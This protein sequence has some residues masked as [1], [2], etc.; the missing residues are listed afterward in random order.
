M[1][2][3]N[4]QEKQF[5]QLLLILAIILLGGKSS[6]QTILNEVVPVLESMGGQ[7]LSGELKQAVRSAEEISSYIAAFG[8]M[9][10]AAN[11]R[12]APAEAPPAASAKPQFPLKPIAAIAP[13]DIRESLQTHINCI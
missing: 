5:M 6:A 8:T 1:L 12:S 7:N 4:M 3:Q 10:K 2:L 11:A 9:A 13:P